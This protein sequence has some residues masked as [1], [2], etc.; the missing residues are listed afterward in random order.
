MFRNYFKNL[1]V[2]VFISSLLLGV[3]LGIALLIVGET[4]MGAD[5]TFDFGTF[6]GIWLML[7]LPILATLVFAILSPLSYLASRLIA[8]KSRA[9]SAG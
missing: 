5:F 2:T 8:R 1:C 6:D 4:S 7:L 3:I 9:G